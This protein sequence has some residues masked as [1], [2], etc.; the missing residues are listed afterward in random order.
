MSS[1]I[2][3]EETLSLSPT[4]NWNHE[5]EM[6]NHRNKKQC[7]TL[8][9]KFMD[10]YICCTY[11]LF[12]LQF[13]L[14]IEFIYAYIKKKETKSRFPRKIIFFLTLTKNS[15]LVFSFPVLILNHALFFFGTTGGGYPKWLFVIRHTPN[16]RYIDACF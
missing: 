8:H 15:S 16:P 14:W 11:I 10:F 9:S 6:K 4:T 12:V 1:C 2:S 13:K 5:H 3:V 7:Y